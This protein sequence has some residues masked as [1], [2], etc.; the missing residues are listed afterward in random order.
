MATGKDGIW[1]PSVVAALGQAVLAYDPPTA[2]HCD[3]VAEITSLVAAEL[4]LDERERKAAQ[5]SGVVHDIGKL[6]IPTAILN[7]AAPLSIEEKDKLE[8]HSLVGAEL[9]LSVGPQFRHIADGVRSHHERWD[10]KGYPDGLSGNEIPLL[11]RMLA[12]VDVFDAM[13]NIRSYRK[14]VYQFDAAREYLMVN[15]G[16]QFDPDCVAAAL[17]VLEKKS[18]KRSRGS[19]KTGSEPRDDLVE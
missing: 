1:G 16:S 4:D 12:V 9:L 13:T 10:G 7:K 8:G 11:G 5:L 17:A 3:R 14:T 19:P 15:S 2:Q 18:R 6:S